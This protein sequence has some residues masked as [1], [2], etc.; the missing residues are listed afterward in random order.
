LNQ[1]LHAVNNYACGAVRRLMKR[2]FRDEE[3]VAVLRQISEETNRA[4]EIVRRVRRFVQ[5][6]DLQLSEVLVNHLIEEVVHLNRAEAEERHIRVVLDLSKDVPPITGDPIQIEQVI[7]NLVRNGLEA[8]DE[9]PD[10]HRV[11]RVDTLRHDDGTIEV[12]VSDCGTGIG[13]QDLEKIFEPFFTTKIEGMGM[14][15]AISRS[16]VQAHGGRLWA[17]ANPEQGCTFHFTLP[18]GRPSEAGEAASLL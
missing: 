18:I 5:K 10:N 14:G 7:L 16:I 4:A 15:L 9:S 8:M 3:L 1:P 6:R 11:L 12:T 17:S 13:P 2:P